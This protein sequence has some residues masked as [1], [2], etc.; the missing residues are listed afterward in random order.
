MRVG[1][2]ILEGEVAVVEAEDVLHIGVD[3]HGRQRPRVTG[4]LQAHLVEVVLVDMRV[5]EGVHKVAR[6][7]VADLRHHH[8]QQGVAGNIEWHAQE[9]VGAALV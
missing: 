9:D 5:A 6:L 3:A 1:V 2:V 8:R 7:E 4:E